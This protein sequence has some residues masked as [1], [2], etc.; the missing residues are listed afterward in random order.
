M[1]TETKYDPAT[2]TTTTAPSFHSVGEWITS[3]IS[4][5]IR[6]V[7]ERNPPPDIAQKRQQITDLLAQIESELKITVVQS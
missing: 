6:D 2:H 5:R 1:L 7:I 3:V 4:Q